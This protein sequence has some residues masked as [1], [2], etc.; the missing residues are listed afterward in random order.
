MSADPAQPTP[1]PAVGQDALGQRNAA[2]ISELA[3]RVA[4][5]E[6]NS[7]PTPVVTG[8]PTGAAPRAGASVVD[9]GAPAGTIRVGYWVPSRGGFKWATLT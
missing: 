9:D 7:P 3:K 6:N 2:Q 1:I 8:V 5:L 4:A